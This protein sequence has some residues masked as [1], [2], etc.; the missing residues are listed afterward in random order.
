MFKYYH[1]KLGLHV[2]YTQHTL[3]VHVKLINSFG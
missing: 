3:G 2:Q 1:L